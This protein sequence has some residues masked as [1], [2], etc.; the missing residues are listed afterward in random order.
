MNVFMCG[1]PADALPKKCWISLECKS[2]KFKT[3][4]MASCC[5]SPWKEKGILREACWIKNLRG[6]L[7]RVLLSFNSDVFMP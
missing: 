5:S 7:R 6:A 4:N 1:T 2:K 3:I